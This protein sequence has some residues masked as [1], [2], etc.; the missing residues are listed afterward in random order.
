MV[1]TE[2]SAAVQNGGHKNRP[3]RRAAWGTIS[4]DQVVDA[5]EQAVQDGRYEQMTIR[6]LAADLGVGP[7]SLYRHVRD[8]DDLLVE[9]TDRLLADSWKPRTR[10]SNWEA[11]IAEAAERLRKLLVSQPGALHV[12]LR[13]PVVSPAAIDR[14]DAMLAVLRDAGFDEPLAR[15]AYG[16]IHTYTIGF[17][18]LQASRHQSATDDEDAD[19]MVKELAKFTTPQ[20]FKEGLR[21]LLKGI[22]GHP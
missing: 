19:A 3:R 12:Y 9:V 4:R 2:R 8:K 17:S 22:T 16:A 14:M 21:F 7:M 13:R 18:A 10:R 5:A 20:Q 6:S 1:Q 11:W 15:R